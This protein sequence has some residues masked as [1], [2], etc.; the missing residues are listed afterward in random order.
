MGNNF[1]FSNRKTQENSERKLLE[2]LPK[3][4]NTNFE[5]K[6]DKDKEKS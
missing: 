1:N 5:V 3:S 4:K 2:F 6:N